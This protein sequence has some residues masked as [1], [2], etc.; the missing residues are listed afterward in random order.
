MSKFKELAGLI[1]DDMKDFDQQAT[2]LMAKREQVRARAGAVFAKHHD[3]QNEVLA[4]LQ[5]MEEALHDLEG[6]NGAP[7]EGE[8]SA[9]SSSSSFR[10]GERG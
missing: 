4:G 7:K 9:S 5:A 2:E 10:D 6:S 3:S 1:R 8:G